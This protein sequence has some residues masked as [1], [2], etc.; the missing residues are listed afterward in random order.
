MHRLDTLGRC[1]PKGFTADRP[2][3]VIGALEIGDDKVVRRAQQSQRPEQQSGEDYILD[4]SNCIIMSLYIQKERPL[5]TRNIQP[6]T[7][8]TANQRL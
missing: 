6:P 2:S 4:A 3:A 1:G 5:Y 7:G 8:Q